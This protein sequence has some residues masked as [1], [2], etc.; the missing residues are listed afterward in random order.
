MCAGVGNDRLL[1]EYGFVEENNVDDTFRVFIA[2][3][4]DGQPGGGCSVLLGR[5]GKVVR[6][7]PGFDLTGR[8]LDRQK[9]AAAVG[10]QLELLKNDSRGGCGAD[11][12]QLE[13]SRQIRGQLAKK[14][15]D[16]KIRL[17]NEAAA[18]IS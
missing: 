13:G 3:K 2:D 5:Y 12:E 15:R 8:S 10:A 11:G 16:E 4:D 9:L 14:W 1:V 18:V 17:L 6:A 7:S